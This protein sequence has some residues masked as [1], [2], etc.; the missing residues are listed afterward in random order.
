MAHD[1]IEQ[2]EAL[3]NE[4]FTWEE[5]WQEIADHMIGR[6]DFNT[7]RTPG[8]RRMVEIYDT[9][10]LLSAELL[11]GALHALMTNTATKWF[12][13]NIEDRFLNEDP[14]VRFW[15]DEIAEPR[16]YSAI[17]RPA[18]NF[19]PQMHEVYFDL[20]A[21]CTASCFIE[22]EPGFGAVFSARPMGETYIAEDS[23]GR[24]DTLY[25]KIRRSA[26]Q[27]IQDFGPRAPK[28]ARKAVED[29]R[30]EERITILHAIRP[31]NDPVPGRLD[32]AGMPW[33]SL[34]FDLKE[35]ELIDQG[36]YFELPMMVPRWSK[37][38]GERYGRGPGVT[39]LPDVKMLN[40]IWKTVIRK[41]YLKLLNSHIAKILRHHFVCCY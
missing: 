33:E 37:D 36:G 34:Y 23:A 2:F 14:D 21:F 29:N 10:G 32:R 4:R 26:R 22:D 3:A 6:R 7:I 39:A 25:R 11:A 8:D 16:M 28:A 17:N 13:L 31:R 30:P 19:N 35:K 1:A 38:S 15:I 18:A 24:I 9:T 12:R 5:M 40:A 27:T 20:T 41:V